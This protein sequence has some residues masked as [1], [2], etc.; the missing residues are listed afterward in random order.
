MRDNFLRKTFEGNELKPLRLYK[1]LQFLKGENVKEISKVFNSGLSESIE[2]EAVAFQALIPVFRKI[3]ACDTF[4]DDRTT[5]FMEALGN[6]ENYSYDAK[7]PYHQRLQDQF[8]HWVSVGIEIILRRRRTNGLP[9]DGE[10][11]PGENAATAADDASSN[12][13]GEASVVSAADVAGPPSAVDTTIDRSQGNDVEIFR[14][15]YLYNNIF[16]P[17]AS[18]QE[19]EWF[20]E[21]S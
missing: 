9:R 15:E 1:R 12:R 17:M 18:S 10:N 8:L 20:S 16:Q 11:T 6:V 4:S 3:I 2:T 7:S 13:V 5:K 21:Y 19:L 14:D